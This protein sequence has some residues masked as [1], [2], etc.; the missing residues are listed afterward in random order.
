MSNISFW[1]IDRTLSDATIEA[2]SG[3]GS[4]DNEGVLCIPQSSSIT[5]ASPSDCLVSHP[6]HSLG[7]LTLCRDAVGVYYSPGRF[8]NFIGEL[9]STKTKNIF[10][11]FFFFFFTIIPTAIQT[12]PCIFL[13]S[14]LKIL[15]RR[16]HG[17]SSLKQ[18]IH[19]I[20]VSLN[21]K[22]LETQFSKIP[23]LNSSDSEK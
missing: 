22:D 7:S 11:L 15:F 20:S 12:Y 19:I 2:Q 5:W 14:Y 16:C 18:W 1:F 6:G 13:P 21:Y 8:G 3:P 4:D 23:L 10:I 17:Q 9:F